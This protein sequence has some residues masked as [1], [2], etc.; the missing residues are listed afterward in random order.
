MNRLLSVLIVMV[1]AGPLV[2]AA[3]PEQAEFRRQELLDYRQ[4]KKAEYARAQERHEQRMVTK[5]S[6]VRQILA[7]SP[8]DGALRSPASANAG[9]GG[10]AQ[11]AAAAARRISRWFFPLTALLLIGGFVW[12]MRIWTGDGEDRRR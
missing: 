6:E 9:S 4:R 7:S 10:A 1:C 5:D 8:W 2:H 3:L 12:L 11:S